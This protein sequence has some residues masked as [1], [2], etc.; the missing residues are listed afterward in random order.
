MREKQSV[1]EHAHF[2]QEKLPQDQG[3]LLVVLAPSG[4]DIDSTVPSKGSTQ[5]GDSD[6]RRPSFEGLRNCPSKLPST[7]VN[8]G[9]Y[10]YQF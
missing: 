2:V 5:E 4:G 3:I 7:A 8:N 6:L 9:G 1:D 10:E